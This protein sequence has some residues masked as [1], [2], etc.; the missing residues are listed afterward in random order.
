MKSVYKPNIS[1]TGRFVST[2]AGA[3]LAALGYRK[4]NRILSALGLGLVGRGASGWCPVTAAMTHNGRHAEDDTRDHLSGARGVL[5]EDV[6]TIYRPIDEVY[7]YWRNLENLP[8]FME[9]L[10]DVRTLDSARSRW[11]AIGPLGVRVAWD[12]EIIND[13]P[14]TLISWKSVGDADVVSAGSVRFKAVGEH[15]TELSVRLQYDPPAGRVGA[16]IAWLLGDDPQHQIA[17]DLRRFKQILE[18]GELIAGYRETPARQRAPR[19]FDDSDLAADF[20]SS[21]R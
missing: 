13:I 12:A 1:A 19:G 21:L 15:A 3:T 2:V 11:V 17:Q 9:H 18:K 16:T 14:P 5:V 8:Q 20:G 7:N 10:D 4:R 6:I